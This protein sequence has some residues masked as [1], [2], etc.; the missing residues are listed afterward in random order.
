M[1]IDIN[2]E[3]VRQLV[4]T[5]FPQWS[6]LEIR[7]VEFSGW[8]NRTFHLGESMLVRLPSAEG[9]IQQ[10]EKEQRWLPILAKKLPLTI[11]TL[12]AK[13]NPD[14]IFPWKWGIYRWIEGETANVNLITNLPEFANS[15]AQFLRSLQQINTSGA[16]SAGQHS[17]F[18]GASLLLYD[19]ETRVAIDK[20]KEEIDTHLAIRIWE[21]ALTS[22]WES[23]P[24]W[25]HGDVAS[26]N[27]IVKDGQLSA[28]LDFGCCG[29]GDPSCDLAIAW[30]LLLGK[31]R[32]EFRTELNIDNGTWSRGS[33]WALW[34][35][36]I[37]IQ[38]SKRMN[39]KAKGQNARNTLNE[40][41]NDYIEENIT[42]R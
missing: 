34:K 6:K 27:L 12:L 1:Q 21:D 7:T 39:I 35:A 33:G 2:T 10:A 8:D 19:K 13:G 30:T 42:T 25:F 37:S 9:Y 11:P 26:D 15:L 31:S 20:L 36:L 32:K 23:S 3:L 22:K 41:F 29:V 5:Q 14:N 40:I 38:E 24:V 28:V 4:A 16:P 17:F 18:R